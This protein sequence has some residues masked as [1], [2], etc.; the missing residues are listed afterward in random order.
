MKTTMKV[1]EMIKALENIKNTYGDT[2]LKFIDE[3]GKQLCVDSNNLTINGVTLISFQSP[4]RIKPKKSPTRAEME[5]AFGKEFMR[6]KDKGALKE[7]KR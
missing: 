7:Y 2:D 3:K 5:K 1:S 6:S 4:P